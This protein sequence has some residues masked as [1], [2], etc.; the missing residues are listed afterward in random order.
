MDS[1]SLWKKASDAI[2][3]ND[4]Y[5]ADQEKIKVETSQR[6]REKARKEAGLP[7]HGK[8]FVN[9]EEDE[10][11]ANWAFKN[12]ITVDKEFLEYAQFIYPLMPDN[13]RNR[14]PRKMKKEE[15]KKRRGL[16]RN[17]KKLK[18]EKVCCLG[19]CH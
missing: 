14:K 13:S 4:L 1:L 3:E 17:L 19:E 7:Y 18:E 5:T 11:S 8:F 15:R 9:T 6:A 16:A 2:I 10:G 12:E